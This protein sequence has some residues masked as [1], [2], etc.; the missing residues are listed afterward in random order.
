MHGG[1]DNESPT[2]PTDA[3][4]KLDALQILRNNTAL[5]DK[6][7]T[8]SSGAPASPAAGSTPEG[9]PSPASSSG[10]R[11]PVSG[12]ITIEKPDHS[13]TPT[14]K[15]GGAAAATSIDSLVQLFLNHLLKPREWASAPSI[16]QPGELGDLDRFYF[17]SDHILAIVEQALTT[18]KG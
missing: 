17:R 2:V 8:F 16:G 4:M 12:G 11:T 7:K 18:V 13:D 10:L 15:P 9:G 3:I 6:I 1:F 14:E 5:V